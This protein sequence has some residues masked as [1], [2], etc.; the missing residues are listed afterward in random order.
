MAIFS[1]ALHFSLVG[2]FSTYEAMVHHDKIIRVVDKLKMI[3][4]RQGKQVKKL[5]LRLV[6]SEGKVA[7]AKQKLQMMDSRK[8]IASAL[9]ASKASLS[10]TVN[11]TK[12][13]GCNEATTT[14]ALQAANVPEDSELGKN[15]PLPRPD[16][17]DKLS[18]ETTE[19]V[20]AE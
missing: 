16:T 2:L 5:E 15:I 19:G 20:G 3:N 11:A 13:E 8:K 17:L 1:Q 7:E 14:S 10:D 4:E 18:R 12:D 9:A 6:A